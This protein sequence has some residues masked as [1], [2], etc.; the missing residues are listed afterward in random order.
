MK[1][2]RLDEKVIQA[3][4]LVVEPEIQEKYGKDKNKLEHANA[5]QYYLQE[6]LR[7]IPI[8]MTNLD[9]KKDLRPKLKEYILGRMDGTIPPPDDSKQFFLL[10]F[11]LSSIISAI[12]SFIVQRWLKHLYPEND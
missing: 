1:K 11:L 12:I 4:G 8:G 7:N 2:Q 10:G 9:D 6:Y 3:I 5:A